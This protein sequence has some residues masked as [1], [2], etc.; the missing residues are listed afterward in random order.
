MTNIVFVGVIGFVVFKFIQVMV[1]NRVDPSVE[2]A[3]LDIPEM[4]TAGYCGVKMDKYSET[5]MS[6]ITALSIQIKKK[7]RNKEIHL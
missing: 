2:M 1:G 7:K 3:G 6:T 5:P 4:G